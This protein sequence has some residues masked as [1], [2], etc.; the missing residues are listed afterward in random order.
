MI[1]GIHHTGL[2]V[3]DL[4]SALA[5]YTQERSFTLLYRF[6]IA[7]NDASRTMLQLPNAGARGAFFAR[8]AGLPRDI[9]VRGR[10]GQQW[11]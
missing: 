5:F 9:S 2:S 6:E 4:D 10:T 3:R 8:G 11:S 1:T 7:D